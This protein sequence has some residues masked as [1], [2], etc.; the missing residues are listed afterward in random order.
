MR[1][2][3]FWVL[4]AAFF[5]VH[6]G[7]LLYNWHA[8]PKDYGYDAFDHINYAKALKRHWKR[9][10]IEVT[11]E[12]YN[13]PTY[14]LLVAFLSHELHVSVEKA[15][16]EIDY[17]SSMITF[18]ILILFAWF[19]WK[20]NLLATFWFLG[21]YV[22][23]PTVYKVFCMLRT[24]VLL[25]PIFALVLL[26]IAYYS[27]RGWRVS[28]GRYILVWAVINGMAVSIRH[29]GFFIVA[30]SVLVEF[31]LALKKKRT[32]KEWLGFSLMQFVVSISSYFFVQHVIG[33]TGT[34]FNLAPKP[35]HW[36]FIFCLRLKTLFT[37]PVRPG[38]NYCFFPSLYA[39]LWGDY[40][41]YWVQYLG[42][43][44]IPTSMKAVVI[45]RR[46]MWAA[47]VPTLLFA[48]GWVTAVRKGF[49]LF[50]SCPEVDRELS[51]EF[52]AAI[53]FLV[54]FILYAIMA[55]LYAIPH[56]G[57]TVKGI[58]IVYLVPIMAAFAGSFVEKMG[59]VRKWIPVLLYIMGICFFYYSFPVCLCLR[60]IVKG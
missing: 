49:I 13:P 58:Y 26:V 14:Y 48:G 39:D 18:A 6:S 35:F 42:V 28:R 57:D 31:L 60:G 17:A 44:N 25:L 33:G 47:I 54:S 29:F 24:E 27:K 4:A 15:G 21:F 12:F 34:A 19:L 50:K 51:W 41:R 37:R 40:W 46:A 56:K 55:S 1:G 2:K 53:F 36:C 8:Y 5:L 3:Y 20:D 7:I 52:Y 32:M 45:L 10:S 43:F 22:F 11:K 9:P 23:S 59:N 16:R 30:F 38:L